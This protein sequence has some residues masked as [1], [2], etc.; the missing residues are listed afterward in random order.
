MKTNVQLQPQKEIHVDGVK[1]IVQLYEPEF[2]LTLYAKLIRRLGEP[3]IKVFGMLKEGKDFKSA[4]AEDIDMTKASDV[5]ESL[6][7]HI[8][9]DDFVPLIKEILSSTFQTGPGLHGVA[10]VDNFSTLFM[11]KYNHV[12]KLVA[13]TL[14]V[15]YPDFLSVIAKR[16]KGVSIASGSGQTKTGT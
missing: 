2:G 6:F 7:S 15:Q 10:V 3:L 11:G 8:S 13:K 1:Y 9:E 4:T 12:F 14:G 16:S 5:L